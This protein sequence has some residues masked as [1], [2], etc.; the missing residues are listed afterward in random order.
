MKINGPT[1]FLILSLLIVFAFGVGALTISDYLETK[2]FYKEQDQKMVRELKNDKYEKCKAEDTLMALCKV[3]MM[4]KDR[5][6]KA[7]TVIP[8]YLTSSEE[9]KS[10]LEGYT[11]A[12]RYCICDLKKLKKEC[13]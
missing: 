6:G 4:I 9:R 8:C 11:T 2:N 12:C 7:D 5:K 1:I 10:F 13:K 3:E